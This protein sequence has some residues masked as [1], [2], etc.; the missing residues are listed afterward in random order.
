MIRIRRRKIE[1]IIITI[2]K[3]AIL[4]IIVKIVVRKAIPI[5]LNDM[6]SS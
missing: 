1:I 2:K 6:S 4:V 5:N 3:V